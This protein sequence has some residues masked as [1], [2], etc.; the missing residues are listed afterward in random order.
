MLMRESLARLAARGVRVLRVSSVYETEPVGLP[1]DRPLL[2]GTVEVEG[3]LPPVELL[4]ACLE[5]ERSMGRNRVPERPDLGER[6][7]DLDLLLHGN[8]IVLSPSLDLPHPRLHER[9]FVLV[10]LA[11]IAPEVIHPVLGEPIATL[12]ARCADPA[13]V[14]PFGP[15]TSWH[16]AG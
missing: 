12:L 1:G 8:S 3:T 14:R 16:P 5:V 4:A 9:R 6:P 13:W 11:E 7:I 15:S 2:N 10:P